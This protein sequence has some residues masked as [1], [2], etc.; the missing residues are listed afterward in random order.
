[1]ILLLRIH[2]NNAILAIFADVGTNL[3][4]KKAVRLYFDERGN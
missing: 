2:G 3:D 1:M 4:T